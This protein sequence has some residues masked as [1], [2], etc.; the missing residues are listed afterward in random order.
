MIVGL[1]MW[2]RSVSS[3]IVHFFTHGVGFWVEMMRRGA[4]NETHTDALIT[5]VC[6]NPHKKKSC[7]LKN[8]V[9]QR[10][11]RNALNM[12]NYVGTAF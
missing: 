12:G 7:I 4:D 9:Q 11:R 6:E 1:H 5:G 2:T 10:K 3:K 8:N